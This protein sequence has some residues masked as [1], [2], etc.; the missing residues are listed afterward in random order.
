MARRRLLKSYFYIVY[1]G[2]AYG[3]TATV[4]PF[5]ETGGTDLFT[6]VT[7]RSWEVV[8]CPSWATLSAN[9]GE[10]EGTNVISTN[11]TIT[12][13][14][15]EGTTGKNGVITVR[16]LDQR[17]T[18]YLNI[19]Q[20]GFGAFITIDNASVDKSVQVAFRDE[21]EA[22]VIASRGG[23]DAVVTNG[24]AN[25]VEV[26]G[27]EGVDTRTVT[28]SYSK[29]TGATEQ[30]I[31]MV[32]TSK[33]DSSIVRTITITQ[34]PQSY[35][36]IVTENIYL[37]YNGQTGTITVSSNIGGNIEN[38]ADQANRVDLLNNTFVN[39][40]SNSISYSAKSLDNTYTA[41]TAYAFTITA[42][43]SDYMAEDGIDSDVFTFTYEPYPYINAN[44]ANIIESATTAGNIPYTTNYPVQ[45]TNV[46]QGISVALNG[47]NVEYTLPA[48]TNWEDVSY[49][50][51][52]VTVPY[53]TSQPDGVK[54]PAISKTVTVTRKA[55]VAYIDA[56]NA[57]A[58][59]TGGSFYVDV[60]TNDTF[61]V[62]IGPGADWI[63][64]DRIEGNRV[65]F[66]ISENDAT[67]SRNVPIT[68]TTAHN[69]ADGQPASKEITLTQSGTGITPVNATVNV[70]LYQDSN[71]RWWI[72]ASQTEQGA[73][74]PI[75]FTYGGTETTLNVA[76]TEAAT[77]TQTQWSTAAGTAINTGSIT[78]PSSVVVGNYEYI[79]TYA[80]NVVPYSE[81]TEIT[82][83][84][85]NLSYNVDEISAGGGTSTP[86]LTVDYTVTTTPSYGSV[87][88]DTYTDVAIDNFEVHGTGDIN[89][90]NT[91]SADTRG[92]ETGY[93]YVV[94]TITAVT[95][96][97]GDE[98]F[99]DETVNE[100]IT[101]E[102]N[103]ETV[104]RDDEPY[105]SEINETNV[106]RI[107]T[108]TG[109]TNVSVSIYPTGGTISAAGGE[110]TGIIA[111][112]TYDEVVTEHLLYD[113]VTTS[114]YHVTY[115][116]TS[117]DEIPGEDEEETETTGRDLS[118]EN[119]TTETGLTNDITYLIDYE[120]D[121]DTQDHFMSYSYDQQTETGTVSGEN[122]GA[123][124][125]T[126]ETLV[127]TVTSEKDSTAKDS[128]TFDQEAN[129]LTTSETSRTISDTAITHD[130]NIT[131]YEDVSL[132]LYS[133]EGYES[134]GANGLAE[135][136]NNSIQ[137]GAEETGYTVVT[138]HYDITESV[139]TA[140]TTTSAY[141]SGF[142]T[143]VTVNSET[144][145]T[146][147]HNTDPV[148]KNEYT[149]NKIGDVYV[150]Q[151]G[152]DPN[153][154]L[155]YSEPDVF[156]SDLE[157]NVFPSGSITLE[158]EST[159]GQESATLTIT[160][161]GNSIT[162]TGYTQPET[163]T[164]ITDCNINA[165][166]TSILF[167]WDDKRSNV[168]V[169][170]TVKV[171]ESTVAFPYSSYTSGYEERGEAEVISSTVT[172]VGV[173]PYF[174]W[175]DET[176][177]SDRVGYSIL[178]DDGNGNY[179][180]QFEA[181]YNQIEFPDGE[182]FGSG[183]FKNYSGTCE[184]SDISFNT[185][186]GIPQNSIGTQYDVTQGT[187]CSVG[188]GVN[189]EYDGTEAS[190]E[191]SFE[192]DITLRPIGGGLDENVTG[193]ATISGVG[194]DDS[195]FSCDETFS[196]PVVRSGVNAWFD[197]EPPTGYYVIDITVTHEET[198]I[199]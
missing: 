50:F 87:S 61:G 108:D 181:T 81:T 123:N 178:S 54:G 72:N 53:S 132:S 71:G 79:L 63:T 134:F 162:G 171:T 150:P 112:E 156:A 93:S 84:N 97:I 18:G 47:S 184:T 88:T 4:S 180:I 48:N 167:K 109:Y 183:F 60:D 59:S 146:T 100:T 166:K 192:Y 174:E 159:H 173:E 147:T 113:E 188:I 78:A 135:D 170:S 116:Y 160:Q 118:R 57:T 24:T 49:S 13:S 20:N 186:P 36:D 98:S 124:E 25:V 139:Y 145:E 128:A 91:V 157:N 94:A 187:F 58:P 85:V 122:L 90:D 195:T 41:E 46:S 163:S 86:S 114:Y 136:G 39:S 151:G 199:V 152:E 95:F 140:T 68:F 70:D 9:G 158:V 196:G 127:L 21:E 125:T 182:Y 120:E 137:I 131:T 16:T 43:T 119:V 148:S 34:A 27:G 6:I 179:V 3:E 75:G 96:E 149:I 106:R 89:A 45:I 62:E 175:S 74:I 56:N 194:D 176:E 185:E 169:T 101:Q 102:E 76:D 7:N 83:D 121:P 80:Y 92:T 32:L 190:W 191:T 165:D 142:E 8:D 38:S 144:A 73:V 64:L 52:I 14:A 40:T 77:D 11:V 22:F 138:R 143:A 29:N 69:G 189:S 177:Y 193:T 37:P 105:D 141:T 164:G 198:V 99:T 31:T 30:V 110:I 82:I 26:P 55:N 107:G 129:E 103:K 168:N 17:Y 5:N 66:N 104:V 28:I 65:Y 161:D 1:N 15:N 51:D 117:G 130:E 2:V 19:S 197:Y 126:G 133:V 44:A 153:G 33:T 35:V 42:K 155:T 23:W 67:D 12:V 10:K 172:N 111:T 115:I 154:S